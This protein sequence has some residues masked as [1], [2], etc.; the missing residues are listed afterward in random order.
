M[1]VESHEL[2]MCVSLA[3]TEFVRLGDSVKYVD[4]SGYE[5]YKLK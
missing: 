5:T 4:G 3:T 1:K 2:Y